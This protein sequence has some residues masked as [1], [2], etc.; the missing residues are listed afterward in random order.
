MADLRIIR[1]HVGFH[2]DFGGRYG[3]EVLPPYAQNQ[4]EGCFLSLSG[5]FAQGDGLT[6]V[7]ANKMISFVKQCV[8]PAVV[9]AARLLRDYTSTPPAQG[10]SPDL[11]P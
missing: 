11:E 9:S 4:K 2:F 5:S 6:A 7:A 1:D 10:T 8:K 3:L